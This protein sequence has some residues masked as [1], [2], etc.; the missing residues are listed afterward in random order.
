VRLQQRQQQQQPQARQQKQCQ[1]LQ[2][3]Q[4]SHPQRL[5][6][7]LQQ[8]PLLPALS[9][10]SLQQQLRPFQAPALQLLVS[11][12]MQLGVHLMLLMVLLLWAQ[13]LPFAPL[14]VLLLPPAESPASLLLHRMF[15]STAT[16][17][18]VPQAP[19]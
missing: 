12:S 4:S 1:F 11:R 19:A 6:V 9:A 8:V 17:G 3:P 7:L 16:P 15:E 5:L 18:L 14:L 13:A 10:L 2:V